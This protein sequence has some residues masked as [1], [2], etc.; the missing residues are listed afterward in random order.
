MSKSFYVTTPIYYVNDVPHVGHAY[1]SIAADVLARFMRLDGRDV[2]FLTGTDE[3]GQKVEK[4]AESKGM[5]PQDFVNKVS[6]SF[7]DM[8][9]VLELTNDDFIRT[10]ED[11]HKKS[12]QALWEK[13]EKAGFIY[14]DSYAG[15][16]SVR[17][18][19]YY[20]EPELVNGKAPTGADVE[21]VEE[22]SYF[23]KLS[24]FQDKLL[25][26]YEKNPDA[27][28]PKSRRNEVLSFIKGGL[29]DLSISRSTFSWGV[30]VP[31]NEKHVMYV[32]MDALTNYITA[33]GHPEDTEDMKN[34]WPES[35]HIVGKDI[36]RFHCVYWHA[37]LM[38]AGIQ[39]PKRVFAHGWWT[40]E[41][42]KISKS[43]GNVIDP[44]ELVEEYGLD[45]IRYFLLREV[46]FGSDGDFSKKALVTRINSDLANNYGNLVQ[47][48]LSFAYKH[49]E[50]KIPSP[51]AFME[52]D[53][54]MLQMAKELPE[55]M[56]EHAETQALHKFCEAAWDVIAEANRYVDSQEPWALRKT[57]T[58]R[59]GTV[60]YVL[61]DVIRHVA[62][63]TQPIVPGAA[64]KVLDQLNIPQDQ[65]D[66]QALTDSKLAAGSDLIKPEGVFP[67]LTVEAA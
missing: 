30:P 57:D 18:E 47:R 16:Y 54:K 13:V 51:A 55:K 43:L 19:A 50:G 59:M 6:Q 17:D 7:R 3:H 4:T 37:F 32:W 33:L 64:S 46:P 49:C 56:R 12:A 42:E 10:T 9:D 22:P 58:E 38:A 15:W 28:G 66:I 1:T 5:S 34:F 53:E 29:K 62:T 26:F 52:A 41:G 8:G 39:P 20:Q 27:I 21:W 36:L 60:L 61:M 14:E 67:R 65:R 40:N 45:Q 24:E 23:F 31:G 48:V 11:R 25:D 63:L 35:L 44:F 2:K